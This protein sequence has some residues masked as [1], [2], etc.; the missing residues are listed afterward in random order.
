MDSSLKIKVWRSSPKRHNLP[1]PPIPCESLAGSGFCKKCLHNLEA[2]ELRGQNL[3]NKD[4]RA[5]LCVLFAPLRPRE[6]FVVVNGN[7]TEISDPAASTQTAVNGIN[8][9]N[10]LVGNADYSGAGFRATGCVR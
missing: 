7:F 3:D 10:V 1:A 5:M 4:L 6:G 2:K 8:D 9:N